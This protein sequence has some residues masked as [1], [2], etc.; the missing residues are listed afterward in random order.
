MSLHATRQCFW[1]HE[2][3]GFLVWFPW[4]CNVY[5]KSLRICCISHKIQLSLCHLKWTCS[6]RTNR[7]QCHIQWNVLFFFTLGCFLGSSV[8]E[9]ECSQPSQ[10]RQS[11]PLRV[12]CYFNTRC[13][14]GWSGPASGHQGVMIWV[15]L[16]STLHDVVEGWW[17]YSRPGGLWW[18]VFGGIWWLVLAKVK[19]GGRPIVGVLLCVCVKWPYVH[20]L[21]EWRGWR[22]KVVCNSTDAVSCYDLMWCPALF[23]HPFPQNSRRGCE[24]RLCLRCMY[25]LSVSFLESSMFWSVLLLIFQSSCA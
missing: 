17:S 7:S 5:V 16:S 11:L 14:I 20:T 1:V 22:E 25:S 3:G 6:S 18:E 10:R 4:T 19:R 15:G 2:L 13:V 12:S 8:W 21:M 24:A 9:T 23:W